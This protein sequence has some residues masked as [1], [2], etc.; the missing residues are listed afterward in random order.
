MSSR[1]SVSFTQDNQRSADARV[2]MKIA[3]VAYADAAHLGDPELAGAGLAA[4]C[5]S[6]IRWYWSFAGTSQ[7]GNRPMASPESARELNRLRLA[8]LGYACS[9]HGSD[10]CIELSRDALG[11]LCDAAVAYCQAVLSSAEPPAQGQGDR[12]DRVLRIDA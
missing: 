8:A 3:A 7:I 6:A 9:R 2:R 12:A 11:A 5:E 4:M 10:A 1:V